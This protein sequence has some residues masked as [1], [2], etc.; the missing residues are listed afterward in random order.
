MSGDEILHGQN[1]GVDV[2]LLEAQVFNRRIDVPMPQRFHRSEDLAAQLFIDP[3]REGLAFAAGATI[4]DGIGDAPGLD[5]VA[6]LQLQ[7]GADALP[8]IAPDRAKMAQSR[9]AYLP[10]K[11]FISRAASWSVNERQPFIASVLPERWFS[12]FHALIDIKKNE[13]GNIFLYF[14]YFLLSLNIRSATK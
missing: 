8:C 11:D 2:G 12:V 4:G 3:V 7:D 10:P 14:F 9:A 1:G 13:L 5:H 6:D